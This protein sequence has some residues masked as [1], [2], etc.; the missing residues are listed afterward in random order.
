MHVIQLSAESRKSGAILAYIA[1][2]DDFIVS[3]TSGSPIPELCRLI[4]GKYSPKDMVVIKRGDKT[5]FEP[6]KLSKWARV[7]ITENDEGIRTFKH[8]KLSAG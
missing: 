8:V 5:I 4:A 3:L 2:S 7:D 1:E 6:S